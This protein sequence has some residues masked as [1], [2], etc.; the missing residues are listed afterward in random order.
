[1]KLFVV[2]LSSSVRGDFTAPAQVAELYIDLLCRYNCTTVVEFLKTNENY[3][4][5]ETLKVVRKYKILDATA[6]LLERVGDVK[7]AFNLILQVWKREM[8]DTNDRFSQNPN[9]TQDLRTAVTKNHSIMNAMVELLER[10]AYRLP[11]SSREELWYSLLDQMISHVHAS[12]SWPNKPLG[13]T[14]Q[15]MLSKLLNSMTSYLSLTTIVTKVL[16][17]EAYS[18]GHFKDVKGLIM[19]M[20]ETYNYEETLHKT[21]SHILFH[22]VRNSLV[23]LHTMSQRGLSPDSTNCYICNRQALAVPNRAGKGNVVV[24]SCGHL[25]HE[26]CIR[27][28]AS[29]HADLASGPDLFC[30]LCNNRAST[31][32]PSSDSNKPSLSRKMTLVRKD[33]FTRAALKQ[34]QIKEEGSNNTIELDPQQLANLQRI[35][36]QWDSAAL[37]EGPELNLAPPPLNLT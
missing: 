28:T 6:Y 8:K 10:N 29:I 37:E 23:Q 5:D 2:R 4:V 7:E 27:S 12:K 13:H 18:S 11:G 16:T 25:F 34:K 24:F 17:D 35:R 3:R 9:V 14:Y 36:H 1:M 21:T 31:K 33:T 30:P 26:S 15:D 32:K 20:L 22:D 19:G